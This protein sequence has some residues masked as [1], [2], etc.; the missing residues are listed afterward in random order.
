[1]PESTMAG[2]SS[3]DPNDAIYNSN[4]S[5]SLGF[6]NITLS[7]NRTTLAHFFEYG[8]L[9]GVGNV[10]NNQTFLDTYLSDEL[11]IGRGN[12]TIQTS[13][14]QS[15]TWISSDV[16][17]FIDGRWVFYGVLHFDKTDSGSL[18]ILSDSIALSKSSTRP[19]ETEYIWLLE[20]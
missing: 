14:G 2:S 1:M 17:K 15:I 11:Q 3:L 10:T 18:S 4:V 16:G 13:D 7:P 8:L 9:K 19:T 6:E 20:K 12:G 5:K